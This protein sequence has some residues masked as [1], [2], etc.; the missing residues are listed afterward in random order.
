M[1]DELDDFLP[2]NLD[3]AVDILLTIF[4]QT[5]PEIMEMT[6]D[7]FSFSTHFWS[8]QFIRNSWFLWW[9]PNDNLYPDWPTEPPKLNEWFEGIGITHADDMSG[10]IMTTLYRK[11]HN[12][13]IDIETQVQWYQ[14]HWKEYGFAD[15]IYRRNN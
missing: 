8:A 3:E 13:P 2:E 10:I 9:Y 7:E 11:I 14:N 6:E 15:G 5:I 12:L 4:K 1:P